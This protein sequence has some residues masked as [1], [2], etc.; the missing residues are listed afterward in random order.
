M[1]TTHEMFHVYLLASKPYGTLYLG[2][3]SDLIRRIWEHKIKAVPGFTRRYDVDRL[4][5]FETHQ[6]AAAALQRDRR[7]KGWKRDW[8]INLLER[9]NPH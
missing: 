3:T 8:K 9:D 5:W 2:T 4:I 7:V 6:S 1:P